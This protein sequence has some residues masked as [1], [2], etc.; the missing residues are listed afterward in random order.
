M[1][2]LSVHGLTQQKDQEADFEPYT[3]SADSKLK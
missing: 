1:T 2:P 3:P